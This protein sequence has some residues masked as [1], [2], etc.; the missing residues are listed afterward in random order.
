MEKVYRIG[1]F[2]ERIGRSASTVRRW[3]REGRIT[4]KRTS[5]GQRYFDEIDVRAAL[6]LPAQ[7]AD[8]STV[9]YCRASSSGQRGELESQVTSM[10]QF[11]LARGVAVDE[12]IREIGGGMDLHRP[13]FLKLMDRI[14]DGQVEHVLVAH[15]DRLAR[16]GFDYLDHVAQRNGCR[17]TAANTES[18]SPQQE[19]VDDLVTIVHGFAGRLDGL[20]RYEK[21]LK[22]EFGSRS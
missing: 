15:Q 10:G 6:N 12:W 1:E 3:E 5:T 7:H 4:P 14:E 20:R 22:D 16:F 8:R 17:I 9:V 19:L 18:L 21:Q 2:A 13:K 11:C